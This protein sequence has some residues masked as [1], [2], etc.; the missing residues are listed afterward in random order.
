MQGTDAA[1][2]FSWLYM[3]V[4][5]ILWLVALVLAARHTPAA[6]VDKSRGWRLAGLYALCLLPSVVATIALFDLTPTLNGSDAIKSAVS[7]GA[8][9]GL[10]AGALGGL[11]VRWV[12]MVLVLPYTEAIRAGAF[13]WTYRGR[14]DPAMAPAAAFGVLSAAVSMGVAAMLGV[15]EGSG[16]QA[17]RLMLPG[18]QDLHWSLLLLVGV[19]GVSAIALFEEVLFRGV[20]QRGLARMLGGSTAAGWV[21]IV[22]S[23]AVWTLGHAANTDNLGFKFTQIFLLGLVFGWLARHRSVESAVAAH[24]GL[25]AASVVGGL[26]LTP[27]SA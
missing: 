20:L 13:P 1:T 17:L 10:V 5:G 18:M 22:L 7:T 14:R 11:L 4:V 9:A 27:C 26:L 12:W 23:S 16:F 19:T 6:E 8:S 15:G 24:V 2:V 25:N 3:V 21:A